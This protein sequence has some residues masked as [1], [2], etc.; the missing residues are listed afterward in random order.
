[1]NYMSYF[2]LVVAIILF[3][4]AR[5]ERRNENHRDA[6]ALNVSGVC[7]AIGVAVGEVLY[8]TY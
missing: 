5:T 1:M 4:H 8:A 3:W 2:C 7:V 6:K